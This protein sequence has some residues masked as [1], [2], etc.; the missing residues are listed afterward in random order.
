MREKKGYP[1]PLGVT[2]SEG[3]INFSIVVEGG[4]TCVLNL[5]K[6]GAD[7]HEAEFELLESN[8]VGEVRFIALPKSQ[9]KAMEYNYVID[10]VGTVDPYAK[11]LI[12]QEGIPVRARVLLEEYDWGEDAPLNLPDHEVVAYN[13]HVR[14]FTKQKY[15]KVKKKGTFQGVIE[16]IPYLQKL[17]INQIQCMPV[18]H[19][20]ESQ[21]Y[22]NY[23]GYGDAYC[24]AVKNAY[25]SGKN[26]EREL[27]DMVKACHQ[28]GIEVVLNLPFS[29]N[30]K[31]MQ[32]VE[33]LRYYRIEFHVDGFVL[34]PYTVPMDVV[35]SDPI[36][37]GA[38]LLQNKEDFQFAMR[39]FLKGEDGT[40]EGLMWWLKQPTGESYNYITNHNG[41]TLADLVSYNEKHNEDN[42]ENNLDG[43]C[44]NCSYNYGVE[45]PTKKKSVLELRKRQ[46]RN[47]FFLLLSAQGTPCIL[48]GD[49]FANSQKGNNNVYCQDNEISW[50]DWKQLEKEKVLFEYVRELICLRK[51]YTLLHSET[52]LLGIDRNS[53]GVPDISY[54]GEYAWQAPVSSHDKKLGVY[55]HDDKQ[56]ITDCFVA[57][58]MHDD[59]QNF[60]LPVLPR[61]KKWYPVFT[62]AEK[63]ETTVIEEKEVTVGGRTIVLFEGR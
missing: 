33:C 50:L 2:E 47:A 54:H 23:W 63:L 36:L 53:S 4:K 46:I 5:Y 20:A 58:N 14:G 48:A 49:E 17:G 57:Y 40:V 16:K 29:H 26:A 32:M 13:M 52:A 34:N 21:R 37:K 38:K 3:Y 31:K 1:L 12:V 39:R 28:A 15:S 19:F 44:Y 30:T 42:G 61:G 10:G 55:Y 22:K 59:V 43:P 41:F 18:Y 27:K 45:G 62:S 8:A 11:S 56:A 35:L 25:A 24:F 60:A 51:K 6:K 9:V 7:I